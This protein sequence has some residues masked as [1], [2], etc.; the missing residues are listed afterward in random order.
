M[1]YIRNVQIIYQR[2]LCKYYFY[3]YNNLTIEINKIKL[4]FSITFIYHLKEKF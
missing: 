4:R 1:L 3:Y 2:Y